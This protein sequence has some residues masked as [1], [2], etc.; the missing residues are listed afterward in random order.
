MKTDSK[1]FSPFKLKSPTSILTEI[2]KNIYEMTGS[3]I[4]A[5]DFFFI[6]FCMYGEN[7]LNIRNECV[8]GKNYLKSNEITI[9]FKI[10]LLCIHMIDNRFKMFSKDN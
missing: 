4:N 5:A 6:H 7:G 8:H 9:A 2:I 1:Q 3:L 10:T